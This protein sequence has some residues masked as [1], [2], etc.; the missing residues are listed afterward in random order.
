MKTI[1][2]F[3]FRCVC[4]CARVHVRMHTCV[5][6]HMHMCA[7]VSGDQKRAS[8]PMELEFRWL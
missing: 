1:N 6:V 3:L 7:S 2:F 5:F 4:V 8:D